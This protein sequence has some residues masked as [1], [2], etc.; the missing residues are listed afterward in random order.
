MDIAE[1]PV[2]EKF[3]FFQNSGRLLDIVQAHDLNRSVIADFGNDYALMYGRNRV[4][5]VILRIFV[6]V[7]FA[8]GIVYARMHRYL[9]LLILAEQG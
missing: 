8:I 2:F 9:L 6:N 7:E 3:E 5:F 1:V 4:F